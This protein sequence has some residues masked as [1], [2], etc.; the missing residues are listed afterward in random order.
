MFLPFSLGAQRTYSVP[1][2]RQAPDSFA[3]SMEFS[4]FSSLPSQ[5]EGIWVAFALGGHL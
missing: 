4:P 3:C 2:E 5:G 1:L